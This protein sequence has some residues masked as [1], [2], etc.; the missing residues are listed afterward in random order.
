[1]LL[2]KSGSI[3]LKYVN[4]ANKISACVN[5]QQQ[6]KKVYLVCLRL[7]PP[8]KVQVLVNNCYQLPSKYSR[9]NKFEAIRMTVISIRLERLPGTKGMVI[10]EQEKPNHS[11]QMIL[12]LE[13]LSNSLN[14]L[15]LRKNMSGKGDL[16]Y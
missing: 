14:L 16:G 1:M 3:L 11:Q 8:Y 15:C 2:T 9:E 4:E 10:T 7:N 5:L 6:G 13:F 12:N